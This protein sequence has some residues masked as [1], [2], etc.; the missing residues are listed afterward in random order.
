LWSCESMNT[1]RWL[2]FT[3]CSLLFVM[4][5]L[6]RASIVII[7]PE[8]SHDLNLGSEDLGLLGAVFFYAFAAVQVPLGFFLDRVRAKRTMLVLNLTAAAGAVIFAAA[9][10]LWLG[11]LGRVLLGVGMSANIIGSLTLYVSWFKP[12]EF[13]TVS[14]LT[15][16]MGALGG[17]LATSPMHALVAGFG[18]RMAFV[19]LALITFVLT[20]AFFLF[21]KDNPESLAAVG[22]KREKGADLS[23][24]KTIR[25]LLFDFSYVCIAVST[26]LRYGAY[27]AV[28]SLWAGPF[29]MVY[30]GLPTA[31]AAH[32][33]LLL[34]VGFIFGGPA[35][36]LLTDRII[37]RPKRVMLASLVFMAI[38]VTALA[39]YPGP[40][41]ISVLAGILFVYG[42]FGGFGHIGFAHIKA[43][44]PPQM[45]GRAFA[46]ANCCSM[47]G[48][49]LFLQGLGSLLNRGASAGLAAD[50]DYPM[51][52]MLC[53]AALG[54]SVI[55]YLFSRDPLVNA[56]KPAASMSN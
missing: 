24:R 34:N 27:A 52:F 40:V 35:G 11:L 54:V 23:I 4:S 26:G 22:I 10:G 44:V 33:L 29:L 41:N 31:A 15:F 28:Q 32:L 9:Q 46:I 16:A 21:V 43:S 51:V 45:S 39:R 55:I 14:G 1:N 56:E 13:A 5:M 37:R 38:S 50:A 8:L 30:L 49:G 19:V 2:I 36:G 47:L 3:I 53:A 6:F 17:L 25:T 12:S 18:W 48:G 20:A 42:F 7:A